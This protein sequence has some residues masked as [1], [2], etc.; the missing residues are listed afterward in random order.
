MTS[1]SDNLASPAK[2]RVLTRAPEDLT[3]DRLVRLG[4]GINKVV[5]ASEHWVIKRQRRPS[6]IIALICVW[7]V[8]KRLDHFLPGG[9]G[10]RLL[11]RPG[12]QIRF[13]RLIFQ[14]IVL[15]IPRGF[16][17]ATH[18]GSL[19]KWHSSREVQGQILADS[20]LSGTTLMP[21]RVAFPPSRVKIGGWPGWLV[22]SEATE[23]VETTLQDRINDLAR[24]R[25]FD[26]IEVWL[27][28]FLDLRK[29]GWRHGVL[30]LDPHLKNYG[31]VGDRVVLLDA[32]GLTN[33][34]QEIEERLGLHDEFDSPHVRL[35]LEMTLRDRPDISQRFDARWR[36]TVN[37]GTVRNHWPTD[38]PG[39]TGEQPPPT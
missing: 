11:E 2:Q 6:E 15:P 3:C 4:E 26:D 20:Y 12:R 17:L 5:Y 36:A 19:W 25:R 29:S 39:Q 24:A 23:R 13:L 38:L 9:L 35:G 34:W 28:R 22:V 21:G 14:A 7:K 16:W 18:I 27:E 33:D 1:H 37:A 30:S 8:L 32:G 10:R 31:V